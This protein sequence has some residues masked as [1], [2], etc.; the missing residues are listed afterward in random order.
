L[1]NG[2]AEGV[3][4]MCSTRAMESSSAPGLFAATW[5]PFVGRSYGDGAR[6]LSLSLSLLHSVIPLCY[7]GGREG[8]KSGGRG[9]PVVVAPY[10]DA[11]V[12]RARQ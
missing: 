1:Q 2:Q 3:S 7:S 8:R 6:W 4:T 10:I 11:N 5:K 9:E 12:A